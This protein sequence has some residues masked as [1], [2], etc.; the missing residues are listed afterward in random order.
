MSNVLQQSLNAAIV[1]YLNVVRGTLDLVR[2]ENVAQE[3][4]RDIAFRGRVSE[5]VAAAQEETQRLRE[6]LS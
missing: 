6:T 2:S 5:G 1:S 4:E 3:S